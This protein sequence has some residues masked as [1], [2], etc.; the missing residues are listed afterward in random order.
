MVGA[1]VAGIGVHI[2]AR[3]MALAEA[4]EVLVSASVPPLVLGSGLRFA[5]R[6]RHQLKG[7]PYPWH[8]F[9]VIEDRP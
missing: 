6:G 3:I 9:T 8:V 1:D 5:D 2:T 7:V 4:D